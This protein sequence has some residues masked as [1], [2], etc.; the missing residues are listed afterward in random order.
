MSMYLSLRE[1]NLAWEYNSVVVN[2]TLD[3]DA[4]AELVS[5]SMNQCNDI[6]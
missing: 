2:V 1:I 3:L 6:I 5:S 4:N